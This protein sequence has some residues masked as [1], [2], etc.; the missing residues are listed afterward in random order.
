MQG[1]GFVVRGI[2][3]LATAADAFDPL[4]QEGILGADGVDIFRTIHPCR[5]NR[6]R[7]RSGRRW[8]RALVIASKPRGGIGNRFAV[9][10]LGNG[11]LAQ[12]AGRDE[13]GKQSHFNF[14]SSVRGRTWRRDGFA[15][16]SLIFNSIKE[17]VR[18][19]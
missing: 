11:G 15:D 5:R 18:F 7:R 2:A 12:R 10:R 13:Y 17:F 8:R 19:L 4:V 16:L 1:H 14:Q 6:A 3:R 9:R